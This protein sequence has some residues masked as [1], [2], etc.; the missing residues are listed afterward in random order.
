MSTPKFIIGKTLGSGSYGLVKEAFE[1]GTQRLVAIK[2]MIFTP[3][4][5]R[6]IETEKELAKHIPVHPNIAQIYEVL[7]GPGSVSIVMEHVDGFDLFEMIERKK[8]TDVEC[9]TLFFQMASAIHACHSQGIIHRDLK[10][11]NILISKGGV[12]KII[13][14]GLA[15]KAR[16][17]HLISGFVGSSEYAAPEVHKRQPYSFTI[18]CW[19]LGVVLYVMVERLFPWDANSDLVEKITRGDYVPSMIASRL[20]SDMISKL[21]QVDPESRYTTQ[22]ILNHPWLATFQN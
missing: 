11:E 10:P 20:C 7:T 1:F 8:L 5:R 9:Q 17:G 2:I 12:V 15:A 21:L 19:S 16:A 6:T 22:Q 13:D 14:W 4:T 3:Q 18:D